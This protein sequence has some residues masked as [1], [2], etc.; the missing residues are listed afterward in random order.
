MLCAA[1]L[2]HRAVRQFKSN[3]RAR[4]LL[5]FLLSF[6]SA[7]ARVHHHRR[8]NLRPGV[9]LF[10]CSWSNEEI[11]F[12]IRFRDLRAVSIIYNLGRRLQL[13]FR[14]NAEQKIPPRIRTRASR[15]FF[16]HEFFRIS[17]LRDEP[18]E[19]EIGGSLQSGFSRFFSLREARACESRMKAPME[20]APVNPRGGWS[21]CRGA[22]S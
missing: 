5:L 10:C 14:N 4:K 17:S 3:F 21:T 22:I 8:G 19:I 20:R 11:F 13:I 1:L 12:P 16:R 6:R 15:I 9:H 7:P 2:W 18:D